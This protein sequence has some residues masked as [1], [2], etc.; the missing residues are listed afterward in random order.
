M[1]VLGYTEQSDDRVNVVNENKRLE[2][3]VLQQIDKMRGANHAAY[4]SATEKAV[5]YPYDP[6]MIAL[7]ETN[8]TQ[9]FMWLN[10]SIFQPKRVDLNELG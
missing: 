4:E 10:R 6:R 2:E 5:R 1:K 9:A 8:L 3:L 7:A